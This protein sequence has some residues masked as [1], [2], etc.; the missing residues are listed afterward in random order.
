MTDSNHTLTILGD[1]ANDK[2]QLTQADGWSN[3]GTVTESGHTFD[4]Y[5]SN[6]A[7][8]TDPTVT[9]KVETVITDT[10]I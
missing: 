9:V 5:T 10:V 4:V 7:S 6:G 1:S 2:V 3:N 8:A